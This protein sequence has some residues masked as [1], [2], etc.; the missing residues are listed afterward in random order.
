MHLHCSLPTSCRQR[1]WTAKIIT[2]LLY[3]IVLLDCNFGKDWKPNVPEASGVIAKS[4]SM[5]VNFSAPIVAKYLEENYRKKLVYVVLLTNLTDAKGK[6]QKKAFNHFSNNNILDIESE[7]P[8]G[9]TSASPKPRLPKPSA[10]EF[11]DNLFSAKFK[12]LQPGRTCMAFNSSA[13]QRSNR[14][15]IEL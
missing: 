8:N 4:Q 10:F 13:L 12:D 5:V 7:I 3:F 11:S 9:N 15:T 2:Y 1:A 6:V 14:I